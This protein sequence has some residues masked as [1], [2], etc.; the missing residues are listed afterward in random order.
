MLLV[1]SPSSGQEV[2][3]YFLE[4][5]EEEDGDPPACKRRRQLCKLA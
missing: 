3:E 2:N 4:R 5:K 1:C